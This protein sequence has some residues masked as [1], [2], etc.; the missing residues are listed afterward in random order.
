MQVTHL[1]QNGRL[2]LPGHGPLA[3]KSFLGGLLPESLL[4]VLTTHGPEAFASA[5]AGDS[6]TPELIWTHRMRGQRLVPQV[7]PQTLF[8]RPIRSWHSNLLL[9]LY[10]LG[11]LM[12]ISLAKT[13]KY[14]VILCVVLDANSFDTLHQ[15]DDCKDICV[16]HWLKTYALRP[17]T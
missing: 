16:Q 11:C 17:L 8:S 9:E 13:Y 12:Q 6:D 1:N 10:C 15:S 5:I 7:N 2:S 14:N 4:Y 3:Q